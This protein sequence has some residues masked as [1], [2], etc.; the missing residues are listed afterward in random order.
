VLVLALVS[1]GRFR[2]TPSPDAGAAD[3]SPPSQ[4]V[5]GPVAVV[6]A[7]AP[8]ATMEGHGSSDHPMVTPMMRQG[9]VTVNGR[10]PPEVIQR[11][12]RQ[13]FGKLRICYKD[14]LKT[15]PK[16]AG[17]ITTKFVIDRTGAVATANDA[18]SDLPDPK[19]V[20]CVVDKFTDMSFPSPEGGIVVVV[21]P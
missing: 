6:D 1:C 7:G 10:L 14:G 11:I 3:E 16:L 13:N 21:F 5:L 15:N 12:V 20:K 18:G 19:V 2:H 17:T 8:D 4:I 9:D